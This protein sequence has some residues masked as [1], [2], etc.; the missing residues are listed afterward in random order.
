[1]ALAL[2]LL[3][4]GRLALVVV[5][6]GLI[7]ATAGASSPRVHA[8]LERVFAAVSQAVGTVLT[9]VMI[10]LVEVVVML[11][12]SL[13]QLLLRP[14]SPWARGGRWQPRVDADGLERRGFGIEPVDAAAPT[15]P[16]RRGARL[17]PVVVGAVVVA[18][19]VD[20]VLGA[21]VDHLWGRDRPAVDAAATEVFPDEPALAGSP[22]AAAHY[23][24]LEQR[25]FEFT[26]FL[27]S[28][29]ADVRTDGLN[30][31]GGERHSYRPA[32]DPVSMPDLWFFGGSA[33][34]GEGQRDEHTIPSEVARLAEAEGLP[35][36]VRN[37][38]APGY[39][40][41]QE[42]LLFERRLAHD[43][44]PAIAVFYDG[45]NDDAMQRQHVTEDPTHLRLPE[46]HL[47]ITGQPIGR[48]ADPPGRSGDDPF[49]PVWE[50]YVEASL[51]AK[52]I[53]QARSIL[54]GG[55]ASSTTVPDPV[56]ATG[57]TT[58]GRR[59][60]EATVAVAARSRALAGLLGDRHGV[61]TR[62]FWQP[63]GAPPRGYR[64]AAR[65]LEPGT[66]DLTAVLEDADSPV[67]IDASHPNEQGAER[68]ATVL[69]RHLRGDVEAWYE[70]DRG[71]P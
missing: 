36:Q 35:V 26:P 5:V 4:H 65:E 66:V 69:W 22:W 37:L 14:R 58:G 29:L 20:F 16:A 11:P 70:P 57:E 46:V 51:V 43:P 59:L 67:W 50:R 34:W 40:T 45:A 25:R 61:V 52:G 32:G 17:L 42:A 18:V 33:L 10:G 62:F 30:S 38:G 27:Y 7:L 60:T 23:R 28:Q 64:D 55:E 12:V 44:P 31:E 63:L 13:V 49:V 54:G 47:D 15:G 39:G 19:L 48:G 71:T 53:R 56:D 24:A 6:L 8:F 21:A 9:I 68:I 3:G 41:W 2:V 1:M